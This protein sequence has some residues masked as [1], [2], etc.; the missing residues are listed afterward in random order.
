MSAKK[1]AS[2]T[3]GLMFTIAVMMGGW[4][5]ETKNE[6]SQLN[7]EYLQIAEKTRTAET[8]V[9]TAQ[10]RADDAELELLRTTDQYDRIRPDR[11]SVSPSLQRATSNGLR[12]RSDNLP[13]VLEW[14]HFALDR[15]SAS[16]PD[17]IS[18]LGTFDPYRVSVSRLRRLG[19]TWLIEGEAL[20][21][22]DVDRFVSR[23]QA[24]PHLSNIDIV[25]TRTELE[26]KF[27]RGYVVFRV[28]ADTT[29]RLPRLATTDAEAVRK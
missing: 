16:H 25:E 26:P 7:D 2:A 24:S 20:E 17:V 28:S 5:Y 3:A 22:V 27:K 29:F 6:S 9:K 13:A 15:Q 11:K 18:A 1:A 4:A 12:A 23:L 8:G 14:L 19:D 10:E 21:K